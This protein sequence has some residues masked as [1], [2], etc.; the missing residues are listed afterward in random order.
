MTWSINER[1]QKQKAEKLI[2]LFSHNNNNN[3]LTYKNWRKTWL[4]SIIQISKRFGWAPTT[5][6]MNWIGLNSSW[7]EIPTQSIHPSISIHISTNLHIFYFP[8]SSGM[9]TNPKQRPK[10]SCSREITKGAS[11]VSDG[12]THL[13]HLAFKVYIYQNSVPFNMSTFCSCMSDYDSDYVHVCVMII[14][15]RL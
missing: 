1:R 10:K 12:M 2:L 9:D 15:R 3:N 7:F 13:P 8:D 5:P 4:V 14:F 6:Q 11:I